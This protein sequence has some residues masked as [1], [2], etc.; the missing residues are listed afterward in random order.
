MPG[1]TLS[2][3]R[4]AALAPRSAWR[5]RHA[6]LAHLALTDIDAQRHWSAAR[7]ARG[8]LGLAGAV[9]SPLAVWVE[10]WRFAQPT[11][12][13]PMVLHARDGAG[14]ALDLELTPTA[15]PVLHGVAGLSRK[16]E[17]AASYYY[18]M[19]VWRVR[20]RVWSPARAAPVVVQGTAWMDREF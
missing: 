4:A 16:G 2:R 19:P 6:W 10:D 11:A 17:G 13:A 1:S 15:G 20:G 12:T 14:M 7:L 18:S 8:A 3:A 9:A 5:A